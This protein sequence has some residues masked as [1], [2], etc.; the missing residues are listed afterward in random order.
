V[1][2]LFGLEADWYV[3]GGTLA[4]A[5]VTAWL[6]RKAGQQVAIEQQQTEAA[7]RPLIQG[8]DGADPGAT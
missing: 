6:A 4:L 8:P 7:V 5:A 3:A 2:E 1:S